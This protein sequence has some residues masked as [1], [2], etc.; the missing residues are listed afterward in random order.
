MSYESLFFEVGYCIQLSHMLSFCP[1]IFLCVK[2]TLLYQFPHVLS[3]PIIGAQVRCTLSWSILAHPFLLILFI[4][5]FSH[6]FHSYCGLLMVTLIFYLFWGVCEKFSLILYVFLCVCRVHLKHFRCILE[7][8]HMI[9]SG[10]GIILVCAFSWHSDVTIL[11][12]FPPKVSHGVVVL[13]YPL[14]S[15]HI[16]FLAIFHFLV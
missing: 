13:V 11:P 2:G 14:L 12:I 1:L 5:G 3:K 7:C 16:S 8:C 10:P 9:D 4:L 15:F 6:W